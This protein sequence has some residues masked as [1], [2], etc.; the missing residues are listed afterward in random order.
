MDQKNQTQRLGVYTNEF[1]QID[2]GIGL[3]VAQFGELEMEGLEPSQICYFTA[4]AI[5]FAEVAVPRSQRST[6]ERPLEASGKNVCL[7]FFFFPSLS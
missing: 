3:F 6:R 1:S 7:C 5:P 2:T 4:N